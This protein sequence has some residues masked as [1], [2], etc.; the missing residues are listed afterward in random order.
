MIRNEFCLKCEVDEGRLRRP[1]ARA[2]WSTRLFLSIIIMQAGSL[3]TGA[4]GFPPED[5]ATKVDAYIQPYVRSNNFSG[6]I[7]IAKGDRVIVR[8]AYGMANL[9]LGVPN[10]PETRF[11]VASISKSFTGHYQFG[12]DFT[13]N[14][15]MVGVVKREGD[16]LVLISG[17]RGGASYL[18][19]QRED[20]FLDRLYGGIVSFVK[21]SHGNVTHLIWNF[22]QD[23]KA[24]RIKDLDEY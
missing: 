24:V 20:G 22:G 17:D 19:P 14:P 9:E 21:D 15:G 5:L 3:F 13:Y 1:R 11:H 16:G 6:A 12:E 4:Q 8:K 2:L 23:Y 7:L 18:I 10:T